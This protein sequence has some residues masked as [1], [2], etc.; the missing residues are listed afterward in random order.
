MVPTWPEKRQEALN[1]SGLQESS[2]MVGVMHDISLMA[3]QKS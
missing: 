1:R 2:S 3:P